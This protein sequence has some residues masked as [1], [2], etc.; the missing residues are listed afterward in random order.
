MQQMLATVGAYSPQMC[1]SCV[2]GDE[3]S[4]S[5]SGLG[6]AGTLMAK[7]CRLPVK[8]CSSMC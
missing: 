6:N 2:T 1:I 7:L 8:K 5:G 4:A 3:W